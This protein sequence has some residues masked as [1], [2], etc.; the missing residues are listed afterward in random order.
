MVTGTA[1][2]QS[3]VPELGALLGYRLQNPVINSLTLNTGDLIS[4]KVEKQNKT[5]NTV[6]ILK[7]QGIR[8]LS[9]YFF[10]FSLIWSCP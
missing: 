2:S 3:S 10:P 9:K 4:L 6:L 1:L 5:Q 8:E 7:D